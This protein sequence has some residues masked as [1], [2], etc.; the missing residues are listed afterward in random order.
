[1]KHPVPKRVRKAVEPEPAS[2]KGQRDDAAG[3]QQ[4][5][6]H[7]DRIG[8]LT[9]E[10]R[11][12]ER[13]QQRRGA[14]RNRVGLP[15]IAAAIGPHE[16]QVVADMEQRREDRASPARTRRHGTTRASPP[17]TSAMAMH[18]MVIDH[19]LSVPARSM[20]FQ[21]ACS[22]AASRTRRLISTDIHTRK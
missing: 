22:T 10:Q 1:M 11:R 21:L 5:A 19:N 16:K 13:H 18:I 12:A 14:P 4:H 7:A 2:L 6:C 3:H 15:E 20:A 17:Q 8:Q 9:R